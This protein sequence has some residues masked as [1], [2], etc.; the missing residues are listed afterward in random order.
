MSLLL[1]LGNSITAGTDPYQFYNFRERVLSDGATILSDTQVSE[2][3]KRLRSLGLYSKFSALYTPAVRNTS[4]LYSI[5]SADGDA[6]VTR[7]SVK[8]INSVTGTLEEIASNVTPSSFGTGGWG[9]LVEGAR[10]N[11]LQRSEEFNTSPWTTLNATVTANTGVAPDGTTTMDTIQSTADNGNARQASLPLTATIRYTASVYVENINVLSGE[12]IRLIVSNNVDSEVRCLFAPITKTVTMSSSGSNLA[13]MT[14]VAVPF[15]ATITRISLSFTSVTTVTNAVLSVGC[16]ASSRSFRAWGAQLEAGSFASSYIKNVDTALGVPRSA[17][18]ITK[19]GASD[20]IGQTEGTLFAVVD[21][22]A[23][24]LARDVFG[25][26][27]F[28]DN[29]GIRVTATNRIEAVATRTNTT[30]QF[31]QTPVLTSGMYKVAFSYKSGELSLV[32]NGNAP[33]TS[34]S[35]GT[36][37]DATSVVNLG[38]AIRT[39]AFNNRILLAGISKTA[40]TQA[41]AIALTT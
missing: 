15:N 14:A 31:A 37:P 18:V 1:N 21:L 8:N 17:D 27:V 40:L 28:A 30:V 19:T 29:I 35:T 7:G 25:L 10:T 36:L 39:V 13:S 32:Y 2:E 9:A 41:E 4:K 11:L 3:I 33:I 23:L 12:L 20:L 16:S 5:I 22:R 38:N 6:T 34:T 24:S 26:G